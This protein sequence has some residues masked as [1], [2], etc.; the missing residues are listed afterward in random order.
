M[1][2]EFNSS[3][4]DLDE[5]GSNWPFLDEMLLEPMPHVERSR[6]SRERQI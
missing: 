3:D 4:F 6:P 5:D 2:E 1:G